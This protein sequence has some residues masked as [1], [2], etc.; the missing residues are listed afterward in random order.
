[1]G[2][3]S[4]EPVTSPAR[5]CNP[6][7]VTPIERP[8]FSV[9]TGLFRQLGE[10][11]VGRDSTALV[12]LVKNSYDAD[13]T[14]IVLRGENL[15]TP[16]D[17]VISISDNG[18]GMTEA[19]FRDGFLRLA[20]SG[21][22]SGQRRSPVFQRRYT[23]EKGVGRLAAH[24]LAA[25]IEIASTAAVSASGEPLAP[26]L[27]REHPRLAAARLLEHMSGAESGLVLAQI[28]WDLIEQVETLAEI[29]D[30]LTV[31]Y[32]SIGVASVGGTTLRLS[33]LRHPWSTNDIRDVVRQLRNFE[34]PRSLTE[35]IPSNVVGAPLLFDRPVIRDTKHN[36]PG[37]ELDFQGDF[38]DPEEY[39][40]NVL[41]TAEWVLEIRAHRG[42]PIQYA[43]NP[44]KSGEA[45]NGFARPLRA[46]RPHPS[47]EE[48]PFFDA[49][50]LLRSGAV[51]TI[52]ASWAELN[53]GIRVYLEGFRIVPYGEARND[54][55]SLD[56]EYTRRAG[57]FPIDPLLAGPES[58]LS[59]LRNLT[60]RDVSLRLL[61]NRAFFGAVFLTESN[62]GGL[63][64]LVNRE[65]FVPDAAFQRLVEMMSAGVRLLQRARALASLQLKKDEAR[66][67]REKGQ[68]DA[69]QS[70]GESSADAPASD[71][72]PSQTSGS[73]QPGEDDDA[74]SVFGGDTATSGSAAQL[75]SAL[76]QLRVVLRLPE[77][78]SPEPTPDFDPRLLQAVASLE[79]AADRIIE[80]ASLLRVLASVG[81]QLAAFTHELALLVPA[82][83]AAEDALAPVEGMRWP[84]PAVHARR[85]VSD[86]RRALERQASYLVDVAS[87]EGRRRRGRQPLRERVDTA[88]VGFQ[89]A[90]SARSVALINSTD[91]TVRTP[92]IFK[93]ELQAILTNLLSNAIKAAASPGRVD[94]A[95]QQLAAGVRMVV[96]ND[97]EE[98]DLDQ[99][100]QWFVPY[101]STTADVDLLLGQGMG[102]GLAITRDLVSEYG[103]TVKF[104]SPDEGFST[105]VEVV[106]PE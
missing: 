6:V 86:L 64:T 65:G 23:G 82:A 84:S 45:Q 13:A 89:G 31:E 85:A 71:E 11:L 95:A 44:T 42:E 48:G 61:A 28:D 79:D 70:D 96:Q 15:G 57:R 19:Q 35:P 106:I 4:L 81:S 103:G 1:M 72:T 49:R 50:V 104:I 30:G 68:V 63:R 98:V 17:A 91:E 105:A 92:P 9:D 34:P 3:P 69:D 67:K 38:A 8:E 93:A 2:R 100:E 59:A 55:L 12:E 20:A 66:R 5:T 7:D 14:T 53:S 80:D 36:D 99:A 47:P 76:A 21:K 56:F 97:G 32:G 29:Q 51:P 40:G 88:L 52:E 87:T 58:D 18:V 27:R 24:K 46:S 33:R 62:S 94:V 78:D 60:D 25:M 26:N 102:L 37:I 41:R 22:T 54:W 74:R 101:A 73:D 83:V 39:W 16:S 43:I 77:R 10:L 90:A 75:Q